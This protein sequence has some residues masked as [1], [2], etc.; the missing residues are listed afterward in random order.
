MSRYVE[1]HRIT[2]EES[3]MLY[4]KYEKIWDKETVPCE[5]GDIMIPKEW[6]YEEGDQIIDNCISD[7]NKDY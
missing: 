4:P 3:R 5:N 6:K 2:F 1:Y 7:I